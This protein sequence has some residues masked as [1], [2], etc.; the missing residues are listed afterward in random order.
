MSGQTVGSVPELAGLVVRDASTPFTL[1][2]G[3]SNVGSGIVQTRVIQSTSTGKCYI[4][5]VISN[6]SRTRSIDLFR[7]GGM[8][9]SFTFDI[10]FKTDGVMASDEIYRRQVRLYAE[11]ITHATGR[12]ARGV[13]LRV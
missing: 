9:S 3:T 6:Q 12:P 2:D 11:A 10:D 4:G 1:N 8:D 7:I 13:L 5:W